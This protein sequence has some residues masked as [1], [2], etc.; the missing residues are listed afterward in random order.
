M[1]IGHF[2]L[3]YAAKRASPTT[4][5]ATLFAAASFVDILWPIFLLFGVET[6][7]I[8]PGATGLTAIQF[9]SYPYTHSLL[10][11]IV[12]GIVF[13]GVYWLARR[14]SRGAIVLRLL[15]LSHWV[16]DLIVHQPDLPLYPGDTHRLGFGLWNSVT[17]TLVVECALFAIGVAIYF[18][19]TRALDWRGRIGAWLTVLVL[20]ASYAANVWGGSPLSVQ[21]IVYSAFVG[22]VVI[23]LLA[24]WSDRHRIADGIRPG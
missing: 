2:G 24:W 20:V 17:G 11:G 18:A 7:H 3:A 5:L 19:S 22:T 13:G 1:F 10:M 16:L 8:T 14:S 6:I 21:I 12:W 23:L 9:V 15:V 4:S